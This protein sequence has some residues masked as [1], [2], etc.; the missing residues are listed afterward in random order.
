MSKFSFKP[1][2][3]VSH[4]QEG[5]YTGILTEVSYSEEKGNFWFK[6]NVDGVTFNSSLSQNN[7]V[8]NNFAINFVDNDGCFDTDNLIGQTVMFKVKDSAFNGIIYSRITE[9]KIAE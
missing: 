7:I 8:F 1:Q 3:I 5:E 6:I 2:R 4:L 9:I